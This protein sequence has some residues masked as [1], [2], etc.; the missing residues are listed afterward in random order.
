MKRL[1][2]IGV[3]LLFIGLAFAPSINANVRITSD[4][5][6]EIKKN[7]LTP[8]LACIICYGW[9]YPGIYIYVANGG[10][11]TFRGNVSLILT[12]NASIL[13]FGGSKN[14]TDYYVEIEPYEKLLLYRGL[15]LGFGS[16]N[17]VIDM[18]PPL[19]IYEKFGG[20]IF[21]D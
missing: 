5:S 6:Q 8:K 20:F 1:L 13:I 7:D 11:E 3:I 18:P 15:I 16:A 10:N 4:K 19:D 9:N 17:V 14:I 2:A 12:I 21:F